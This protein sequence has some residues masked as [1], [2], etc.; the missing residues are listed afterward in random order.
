MNDGNGGVDERDEDQPQSREE[1]PWPQ[2]AWEH[3]LA[4]GRA[5]LQATQA[6]KRCYAWRS[7]PRTPP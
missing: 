5:G 7:S 2:A 4:T 6:P 3:A 1:V